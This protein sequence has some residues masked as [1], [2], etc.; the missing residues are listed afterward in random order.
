MTSPAP[1]QSP[2]VATFATF[3]TFVRHTIRVRQLHRAS[4]HC[5]TI[6]RCLKSKSPAVPV[7]TSIA[8]RPKDGPDRVAG[9]SDRTVRAFGSTEGGMQLAR[10]DSI[11]LTLNIATGMTI[12]LYKQGAIHF[13][14]AMKE[15]KLPMPG[16]FL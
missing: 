5:R 16:T 9:R 11:V 12:L 10:S 7:R 2:F 8:E 1:A 3:A 4:Q 13:L 15:A 6:H 14:G